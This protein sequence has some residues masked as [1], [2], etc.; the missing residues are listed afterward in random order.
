MMTNILRRRLLLTRPTVVLHTQISIRSFTCTSKSVAHKKFTCWRILTDF[1]HRSHDASLPTPSWP[2]RASVACR[3]KIHQISIGNHHFFNHH[4]QVN[5]FFSNRQVSAGGYPRAMSL[6]A[7]HN[8]QG[9]VLQIRK[10][11]L[12]QHIVIMTLES[13]ASTHHPQNRTSIMRSAPCM[14]LRNSGQLCPW[15]RPIMGLLGHNV[16]EESVPREFF[17]MSVAQLIHSS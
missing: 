7:R 1:L 11:E 14:E 13:T 17:P 10:T 3:T 4:R 15:I 5:I 2:P 8:V 12:K 9:A 16:N 6:Y